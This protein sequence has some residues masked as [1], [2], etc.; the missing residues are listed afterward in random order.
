MTASK[1]LEILE[2]FLALAERNNINLEYV[3]Y[4]EFW[5]EYLALKSKDKSDLFIE[6]ILRGKYSI[7]KEIY[8]SIVDE[9]KKEIVY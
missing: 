6:L 3:K 8:C 9:L 5:N 4:L 7:E 2:P 1:L